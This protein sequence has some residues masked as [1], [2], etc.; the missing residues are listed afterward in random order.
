MEAAIKR[1]H[2]FWH[3]LLAMA[4]LFVAVAALTDAQSNRAV[5]RDPVEPQQ[6]RPQVKP[7]PRMAAGIARAT[8][9][10]K[11]MRALIEELVSCGTRLT[12]SS[13]DDPKRGIGCGRDK[14][15]ARMNEIAKASGGKLQV[16]VDKF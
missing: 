10:E 2:A 9:D 5:T 12:L 15:V 7:L 16:V 3:T 14:I 13:W 4:V 11:S 1:N 6:G 8:I